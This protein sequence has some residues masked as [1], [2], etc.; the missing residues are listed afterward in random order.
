MRQ[1]GESPQTP[2][3]PQ[4]KLKLLHVR[5]DETTREAVLSFADWA[6]RNP[7]FARTLKVIV[8]G[9][10]NDSKR[11]KDRVYLCRNV[12]CPLAETDKSSRCDFPDDERAYREVNVNGD[13]VLW[14]FI[15][16]EMPFLEACDRRRA[17]TDT[18][19]IQ[20]QILIDSELVS[21]S[22]SHRDL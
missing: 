9:D 15:K 19:Q 4:L 16:D 12:A 21:P 2:D 13:N 22:S 18:A 17:E 10:F 20:K 7:R 11:K 1:L 3:E 8:W 5:P 14:A 6:F